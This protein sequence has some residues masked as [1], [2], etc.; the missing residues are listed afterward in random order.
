M[1]LSTSPMNGTSSNAA[2]TPVTASRLPDIPGLGGAISG[3]VG[4]M[5]MIVTAS[6]ITAS[7]GHDIWLEARQIASIFYGSSAFTVSG[8]IDGPVILGTAVHLLVSALLGAVFGIVSRRWL[9]L[10]SD[11][12]TPV[13]VGMVYGMLTWMLAYFVVVPIVSPALLDTYQ[14]SFIIQNI[15]YGTVTGLVYTLLRPEPYVTSMPARAFTTAGD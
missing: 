4:G 3:L 7:L 5:A 2:R 11:F 8:A 12:G 6:M 14:P 15:V 10:P 1:S 9:R 13:L